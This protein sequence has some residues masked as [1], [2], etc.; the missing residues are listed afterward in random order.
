MLLILSVTLLTA[1]ERQSIV[2][3]DYVALAAIPEP[4]WLPD[5]V[6]DTFDA[7]PSSP[8]LDGWLRQYATQQE[9][10]DALHH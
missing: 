6:A 8:E 4:V 3:S 2:P 1:C 5:S 10:L 7:L 9:Q